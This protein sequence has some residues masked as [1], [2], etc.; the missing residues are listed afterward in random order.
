MAE[1]KN[2]APP[3]KPP[4]K[5]GRP[6]GAKG[7][8]AGK[9]VQCLV[10]EEGVYDDAVDDEGNPVVRRVGDEITLPLAAALQFFAAG[11]VGPLDGET[12]PTEG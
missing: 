9:T 3:K 8:G 11:A 12:F 5:R 2:P 6:A 7:K 4:A 10:C 1:A